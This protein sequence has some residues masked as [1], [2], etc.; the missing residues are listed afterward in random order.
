[1]AY[2]DLAVWTR[3]QITYW[4]QQS[5]Q[6]KYLD[7][8]LNSAISYLCG[9]LGQPPF[10]SPL[11]VFLPFLHLTYIYGILTLNQ[12]PGAKS[13]HRVKKGRNT[14]QRVLKGRALHAE[15]G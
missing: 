5:L 3:K 12:E 1:M 2:A 9:Q 15:R 8:N 6:L 14:E 11:L 10:L 13:V 4:R 7:F